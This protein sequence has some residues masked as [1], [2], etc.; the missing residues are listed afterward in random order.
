L[1]TAEIVAGA[2][3]CAAS[4]P[5]RG[6]QRRQGNY[7]YVINDQD[8][9]ERRDVRVGAVDDR[10]VTIAQGL[11]GQERVVVTAGPFLNVGQKVRPRRAAAADALAASNE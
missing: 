7:V 8:T 9:V 10:G 6:P 4:P 5:E 11:S 3:Q 2:H 1:P